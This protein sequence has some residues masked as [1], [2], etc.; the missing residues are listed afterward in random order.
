[1]IG[2]GAIDLVL[3]PGLFSNIDHR[4]EEPGFER[5]LRRLPSF[6]RLIVVDPRTG[7]SDRSPPYPPMEEQVYDILTV[8]D[9]VS[10]RSPASSFW[11]RL[12]PTSCCGSPSARNPAED[13]RLSV[14]SPENVPAPSGLR[15]G[16]GT[17]A[18]AGGR[19]ER[20]EPSADM[21]LDGDQ[22]SAD[23]DTVMPVSLRRVHPRTALP[24]CPAHGRRRE[25]GV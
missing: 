18:P 25:P 5:F 4:W 3:I 22:M 10:S 15:I 6:T 13:R 21:R 16:I 9:V 14:L 19:R 7:L 24:G 20:M 8:L 23:A 12:V 2:S 17:P 11:L 1:V